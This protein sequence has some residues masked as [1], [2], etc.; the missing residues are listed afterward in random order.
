MAQ[1]GDNYG[2]HKLGNHQMAT[3]YDGE[4]TLLLE[5]ILEQKNVQKVGRG[6]GRGRKRKLYAPKKLGMR[7]KFNWGKLT[8]HGEATR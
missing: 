4:E 1:G 2:G 3:H 8:G 5:E 6:E 7:E